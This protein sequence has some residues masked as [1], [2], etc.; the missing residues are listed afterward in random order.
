MAGILLTLI[1]KLLDGHSKEKRNFPKG[2]VRLSVC[3]ILTQ[4]VWYTMSGTYQMDYKN[5]PV[6]IALWYSV[7]I[8]GFMGYGKREGKD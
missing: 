4:A 6:I 5:V 8:W 1:G 2:C 3:C 7:V